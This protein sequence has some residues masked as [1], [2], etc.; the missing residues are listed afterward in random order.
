MN[1]ITLGFQAL[2]FIALLVSGIAA[3][4]RA[5]WLASLGAA[6]PQA[7]LARAVLASIY[8]VAALVTAVGIFVPFAAFFAACLSFASSL[9]LAV[10]LRRAK[11]GRA[12]PLPALIAAASVLVAV[13]QPLGLRVLAL[14]KADE[15][16]FAPSKAKVV[17]T[18]DEGLWFEA[19][20][21]APD[22]TL[23]L[24]GNRGLDFS[25]HAY[26][27]DARG[28]LIARR[29]DGQEKVLFRTPQG[30]TAGV[31]AVAADGSLFMTSHGDTPCIWHID[32]DGNA[33]RVVQFRHGAW[34]NGL[35]IG[36]DG[37]LYTP[38]SALG[39]IWRVDPGTGK[40]EI[41]LED[42][43]LL[44]RPF[45]ALAPGANGLHF[46]GRDMLVTVSDRAT[47]LKYT[48]D[49][50][51][52]FGR[53]TLVATGIPGDD[54]AIGADGA[55]FITTHPYNTLVRV[56]PDG[57]RSVIA[58]A[59]QHIVGATDAVFGTTTQDRDTLYVV[60]DGGAFTGGPTTRGELVAVQP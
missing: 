20:A 5:R 46:S 23:Y 11:L 4:F 58:K 50:Q 59:A 45:I 41:A 34:P 42:A 51:G 38:D 28:E 37:M 13:T 24:A 44:A 9:L 6:F 36:P 49:R 15:L 7:G 57:Q 55:L 26:Y 12:W 43:A 40:A 48:M 21:A 54:F 39:V 3:G 35:A 52:R 17:K 60:T 25:A 29:R 14:P 27:A 1:M 16:P 2:L 32:A 22:G 30:S 31:L 10:R 19:I 53:A 33:K 8:W 56:G 18:Y 47:V